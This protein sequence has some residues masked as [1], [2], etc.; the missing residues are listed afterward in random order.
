MRGILIQTVFHRHVVEERLLLSHGIALT[1]GHETSDLDLQTVVEEP[2]CKLERV[3]GMHGA[4]GIGGVVDTHA[5]VEGLQ[6]RPCDVVDLAL[7][8]RAEGGVHGELVGVAAG[9][10]HAGGEHRDGYLAALFG[11]HRGELAVDGIVL[12]CLDDE[13]Q[14]HVVERL[15]DDHATVEGH[16]AAGA[17]LVADG[18]LG[19]LSGG[20]VQPW[21]HRVARK[22]HIAAVLDGEG[23][24][25]DDGQRV[26]HLTVVEGVAA[27]E[28]DAFVVVFH[29]QVAAAREV[30]V[31]GLLR[32]EVAHEVGTFRHADGEVYIES[33]WL[34]TGEDGLGG[35]AEVGKLHQIV[36]AVVCR[37]R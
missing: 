19:A 27:G 33:G 13:L 18:G 26:F 32:V 31:V 20:D 21:V 10:V 28:V 29:T 17:F 37:E 4:A 6:R 12:R 36:E 5:Q 8:E 1:R 7:Q 24:Q 25:R 34:R 35:V 2:L 23:F 22:L 14:A 9:E 11:R 16:A 3:V 30:Y 15:G